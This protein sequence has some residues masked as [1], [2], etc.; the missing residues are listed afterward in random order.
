MNKEAMAKLNYADLV[1][2]LQG[3]PTLIGVAAVANGNYH[4]VP[5]VAVL[6]EVNEGIAVFPVNCTL[7]EEGWEQLKLDEA[8][9]M[10]GNRAVEILEAIKTNINMLEEAFEV[11]GTAFPQEKEFVRGVVNGDLD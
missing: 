9:L 8:G 4:I 2:A 11:V 7:P 6:V 1:E 3:N 5:S 10:D